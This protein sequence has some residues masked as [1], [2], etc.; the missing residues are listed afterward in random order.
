M[1][2]S[3]M[4]LESP[5]FRSGQYGGR[6]A[7]LSIRSRG[8]MRPGVKNLAETMRSLAAPR[9]AELKRMLRVD[10]RRLGPTPKWG[11]FWNDGDP[12]EAALK[13]RKTSPTLTCFQSNPNLHRSGIEVLC[14]F[15]TA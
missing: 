4:R 15:R 2:S 3:H 11:D 5:V 9:L 1:N 10:G 14:S 12:L 7:G 8:A 13:P 6:G